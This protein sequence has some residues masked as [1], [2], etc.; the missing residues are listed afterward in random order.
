MLF[1]LELGPRGAER[2]RT[3]DTVFLNLLVAKYYYDFHM[4]ISYGNTITSEHS[5]DEKSITK[6]IH[7]EIASF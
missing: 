2:W 1:T 7:F 5:C 6:R 4:T 3:T